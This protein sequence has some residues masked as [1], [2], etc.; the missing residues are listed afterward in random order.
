MKQDASWMGSIISRLRKHFGKIMWAKSKD[1]FEILVATILSQNTSDVNSHRAFRELKKAMKLTPQVLAEKPLGEIKQAIRTA[2]LAEI[3]AKRLKEASKFILRE[4]GGNLSKVFNLP[5][6]ESR[7]FLL[8]LP[9][10]GDKTADVILVFAGGIPVVPV[11]THLF[12]IGKRLGLTASSR[13][14]DVRAAYERL[15]PPKERAEAHVLFIELGKKICTARNPKHEACPILDLCPTGL[16][17]VSQ[18]DDEAE[19]R[20]SDTGM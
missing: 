16:K 4:L 7:N 19:R 18:V 6:E 2:G 20:L 1:S 10:V 12:T 5:P 9:G 11:D 13:Y 8:R 15:I 3:K 17:S 14:Q